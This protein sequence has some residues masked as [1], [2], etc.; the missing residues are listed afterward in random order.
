MKINVCGRQLGSFAALAALAPGSPVPGRRQLQSRSASLGRPESRQAVG[1]GGR[2]P[3]SRQ[4]V[5]LRR[6]VWWTGGL[7]GVATAYLPRIS[8]SQARLALRI[9]QRFDYSVSR[10]PSSRCPLYNTHT[11]RPR[12]EQLS[13]RGGAA[14]GEERARGDELL[15]P[16]LILS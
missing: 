7:A 2:D 3:A 4:T 14:G 16:C 5:Q 11:R 9:H 12:T 1:I 6:R 8:W 13:G 15:S 10:C